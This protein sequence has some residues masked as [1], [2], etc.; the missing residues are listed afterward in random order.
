[1]ILEIR[2]GLC[3]W[4]EKMLCAKCGQ[5]IE[6]KPYGRLCQ[7][8]YRYFKNGGTI[9]PIPAPG[10]IKR[11][12][13]GYV[14][15]HICGRSFKRLGS[16]IRETHHM[17]MEA[18]KKKYGLCARSNTTEKSYHQAMRIN[19]L[20]NHMPERLILVGEKT[21]IKPGDN[22]MRKGKVVCLQEILE[23]RMRKKK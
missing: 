21:R 11:D 8:C 9:N 16:H 3:N 15:C 7:G 10:E 6:G 23:K 4:G 14:V 18:Y 13:R 17:L 19:A 1:M 12:E 22:S 5:P 20:K 2:R